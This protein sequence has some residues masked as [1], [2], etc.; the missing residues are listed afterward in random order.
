[1]TKDEFQQYCYETF[2]RPI[3]LSVIWAKR[4]PDLAQRILTQKPSSLSCAELASIFEA[5]IRE[6]GYYLPTAIDKVL[7]ASLKNA[8]HLYPWLIWGLKLWKK[9][10]SEDARECMFQQLLL[11]FDRIL[12]TISHPPYFQIRDALLPWGLLSGS[13]RNE[14][15]DHIASIHLLRDS[16]RSNQIFQRFYTNADEG[17]I[18]LLDFSFV[19]HLHQCGRIKLN[20]HDFLMFP[21]I[22]DFLIVVD[23]EA[24][25]EIVQD[26]IR[27]TFPDFYVK[28]MERYIRMGT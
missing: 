10:L 20:R 9:Q 21:I 7:S 2:S 5:P 25:W 23:V 4:Q 3:Q 28:E 15:I 26:R 14:F 18:H 8:W 16:Q 19:C 24:I 12:K 11:F 6:T 13:T 22:R 27:A 1:M 17:L